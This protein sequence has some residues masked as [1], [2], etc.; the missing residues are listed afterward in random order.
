MKRNLLLLVLISLVVLGYCIWLWTRADAGG[1][2][3]KK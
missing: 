1:K 3:G 2:I